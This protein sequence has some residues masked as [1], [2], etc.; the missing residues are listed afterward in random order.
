[1][2]FRRAFHN[3]V[4]LPNG[5]IFITGGQ[6]YALPFSDAQ[7]ILTPEMW[8]PETG[9]F[10]KMTPNRIPR[11]YHSIALLLTDATVVSCGGGLCDTCSTNHFDCQIYT[12][13]YL[14]NADGSK[15][16]RPAINTISSRN[17]KPG[18]TITVTTNAAVTSFSMVRY[19]ATTHTVNTDQRRIPL[20]PTAA[21]T[22]TYKITLGPENTGQVLPGY[23]MLFAINAEG[24]PSNAYTFRIQTWAE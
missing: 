13:P 14:L 18:S 3:S 11:N 6:S 4:V 7:S 15:K 24:V 8:T 2:W 16:A 17:N 23:W 21:G 10:V 9:K 22:N 20:T 5:Q 1:M 12:P 19:S